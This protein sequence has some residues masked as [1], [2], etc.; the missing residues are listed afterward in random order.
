VAK[1][2]GSLERILPNGDG[3]DAGKVQAMAERLLRGEKVD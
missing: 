3:Y 2:V 1:H